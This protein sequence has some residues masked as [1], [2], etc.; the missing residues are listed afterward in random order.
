MVK[1]HGK[2]TFA[3]NTG[4]NGGALFMR[5]S[6][7]KLFPGSELVFLGNHARGLGGAVFVLEHVMDEFIHVNNPDCF[8]AYND[9]LVPPSKWKVITVSF[10]G[11]K[12]G[13]FKTRGTQL[14]TVI[15]AKRSHTLS[16]SFPGS[17]LFPS[18][19]ETL[20]TTLALSSR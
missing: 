12:K 9:P 8:L 15:L 16:T 3:N 11:H 7:I 20:G 6:Q 13:V 10:S 18:P 5:S 17:L 4:S 1:V 2:M 14:V 19:T